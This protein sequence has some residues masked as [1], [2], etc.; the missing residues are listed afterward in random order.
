MEGPCPQFSFSSKLNMHEAPEK[1]SETI[2]VKRYK[3]SVIRGIRPAELTY[4]T[5]AIV[6]KF[7]IV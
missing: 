7:C 2:P 3:L 6:D 1:A 5:V 4:S